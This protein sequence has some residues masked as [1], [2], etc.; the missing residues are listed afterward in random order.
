[1]CTIGALIISLYYFF[2]R[3]TIRAIISMY[4]SCLKKLPILFW[5]LLTIMGLQMVALECSPNRK[6]L[7]TH[8]FRLSGPKTILYKALGLF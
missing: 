2:V 7:G 6:A 1:M 8:I 3:A 4:Y 5:G